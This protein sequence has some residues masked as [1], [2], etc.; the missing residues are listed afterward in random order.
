[1]ENQNRKVSKP[2]LP[3]CAECHWKTKWWHSWNFNAQTCFPF[4]AKG[5]KQN[6]RDLGC[7]KPLKMTLMFERNFLQIVLAT[8]SKNW[9]HWSGWEDSE[10]KRNK[11]LLITCSNYTV[12]TLWLLTSVKL[13]GVMKSVPFPIEC[14]LIVALSLKSE[15]FIK[16]Y[17]FF[18]LIIFLKL[19][20]KA[21]PLWSIHI[22]VCIAM[23]I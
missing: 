2:C 10:E 23:Y 11:S 18:S 13:K 9:D 20:F 8:F 6:I 3:L 14:H 16:L 21:I 19:L 4:V 12:L 17:E 15:I 22:T 1:M 7:R 5:F